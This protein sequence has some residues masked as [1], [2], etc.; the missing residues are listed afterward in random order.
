MRSASKT[1]LFVPNRVF[2]PHASLQCE[3]ESIPDAGAFSTRMVILAGR[4]MIGMAESL[5]QP[6]CTHT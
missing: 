4:H 5:I 2:I 3:T 1:S 6:V